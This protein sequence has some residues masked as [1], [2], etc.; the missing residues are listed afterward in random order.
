MRWGQRAMDLVPLVVILSCEGIPAAR[1]SQATCRRKPQNCPRRTHEGLRTRRQ[2]FRA[3]ECTFD[4]ALPAPVP[5]FIDA[6]QVAET[7]RVRII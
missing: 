5:S 6:A 4:T 7:Q 2:A 3:E 1:E